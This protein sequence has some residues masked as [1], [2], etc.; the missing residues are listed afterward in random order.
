[1]PRGRYSVLGGQARKMVHAVLQF[2]QKEHEEGLQIPLNLV[3]KRTAAAT[4]ISTRTVQR[5]AATAS[6]ADKKPVFRTPG[7]KR[8]GV[9]RVTGIDGFNQGVIKRCVHN[10]H[11]TEKKLPTVQALQKKLKAE[12]NYQGSMSSLSRILKEL[13]FQWKKTQYE[14]RVM[15]EQTSIRLQR[16]EYLENIF[17]Y[18]SEGRPIVYA[19]ESYVDSSQSKGQGVVIVHAGSEAGFVSDGLLMLKG[20]PKSTDYHDNLNHDIYERWVR[21]QLLPGLPDNSVVVVDNT[22]YHNKE[23]DPAPS[24]NARKAEMQSWLHKKQIHYDDNMLKPQLYKLI[25]QTKDKCK[26]YNLDKILKHHSHDVLRLPPHH[27]DL[28]PIEMAWAA[29]KK[30]VADKV[31]NWNVNTV[32]ELIEEK[33]SQMGENEW[34][35]F[36]A[37]AMKIEDDYRKSDVVIDNLTEEFVT[38]VNNSSDNSDNYSDTNSEDDSESSEEEYFGVSSEDVPSTSDYIFIEELKA[39]P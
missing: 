11:L 21:T 33:A 18:R 35:E 5:I 12:I 6:E 2:M 19:G 31:V 25:V 14:K 16:I 28:N 22:S 3:Q 37:K 29:I 30:H 20:N 4:G 26:K 32:M 17:K 34:S 13:G 9:K 38:Q 27:P 39:V 15:I 1:M 24:S 8:R 10:F 7:K 36:C 23:E